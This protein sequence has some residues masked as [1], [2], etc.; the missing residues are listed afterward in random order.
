MMTQFVFNMFNHNQ[1]GQRSL[2]DVIG[3][4]GHQLRALD[5]QAVW[6]SSNDRFVKADSG[7]NIVVEGFTAGSIAIIKAAY[8][9]GCR[10]L[11]LATEEPIDGKGFNH[12]KEREMRERMV[13]FPEAMK[14][15][16]GILYLVP[17]AHV[18]EWFSRWCPAAYVDLGFAP[19]LIRQPD[20]KQPIY[21]FGF[22]GSITERRYKI[23]KR[24]AKKIGTPNAV[25]VVG[26]FR[27]QDERDAAMREARVIVQ[28]RKYN[29]M[30]L[31][32][33]S[34]CNTA[35]MIGRPVI[36]EPHDLCKPWDEVIKFSKSLDD[37]YTDAVAMRLNWYSVWM[38]QFD[39]FRVTFSPERCV[40]EPLRSL[41]VDLRH[42]DPIVVNTA[43]QSAA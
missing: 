29:V 33:S 34:R 43:S 24:L 25:K 32:S 18:H 20:F 41:G 27:S 9:N 36:A 12:G 21:D 28:V 14:Y 42:R 23:L 4:F 40:G 35:L 39:R 8:E 26:D 1:A 30:G 31:V 37:F 7:I 11:C 22:Y 2:E 5:H 10:F 17:G 38:K 6:D 19:S 13:M 3:I 15:F 16:E